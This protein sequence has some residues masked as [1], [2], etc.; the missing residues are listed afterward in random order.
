MHSEAEK[1]AADPAPRWLALLRSQG[2]GVICGQ[3]AVV[4][5]GI[6][7]VILSATRGGASARI[8]MDGIRGFFEP[9]AATHLWFYLLVAV[10]ALYGLNTL[11]CTW[12]ATAR[13]LAAGRRSLWHHGPAL[14]HI[15]FLLTLVA[16]L[17]G[18]LWS[19]EKRPVVLT[20]SWR[21]LGDGRHARVI[22]IK[23]DRH[24]NKQPKQITATVELKSS[25][26]GA[27]HQETIAYNKPLTAP[28]RQFS[29]HTQTSVI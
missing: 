17:V 20:E 4:L 25:A 5:L 18:G 27:V 9:I 6:G 8:S 21:P 23:I 13:K 29:G 14:M 7:S 26:Q 19:V 15:A 16:H 3:L 28:P 11:L 24:A 1:I 22:G 12:H 10:F 2:L